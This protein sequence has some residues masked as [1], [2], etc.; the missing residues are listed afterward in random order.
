MRRRF[1]I[2]EVIQSSAM[3]CG[4]ASLKA[5]L[6]G[7]GISA[8]YGRLREACQTDVDGTSIDKLE[9]AG[10]QLGLDAAQVMLPADHLFL[11][12]AEAL[13]ALLVVRLPNGTT[14]FVVVWRRHGTWVQVMDP[15]VGRRWMRVRQLQAETYIHTQA[16]P[17][18]GWREWA[19][20]DGFLNPLRRRIRDLGIN[21]APYIDRATADA[22]WRGLATLDAAT[23]LL[24]GLGR[25][26]A[27]EKLLQKLTEKPAQIPPS[28][29]S[30]KEHGEDLHMMGAVLIH[31]S[32]TKPATAASAELLAALAEKPAAPGLQL[33]KL[34]R[35]DGFLSPLV[36]IAAIVLAASGTAVEAV[37]LRGLFELGRYLGLAGQRMWA[38]TALAVFLAALA[39]IEYPLYSGLLRAGR[40]LE[41]RLRLAFLAG[42]P[43]LGDRYFQSRLISDMAERSHSVQKLREL[44]E[45]AG[46]LLQAVAGIVITAG[47]IV[48]LYP[49]SAPYAIAAAALSLILPAVTQP[50]LSER[51]LRVRSHTGALSRF[52]LDAMIG[53]VAIR[54]HGAERSV[55]SEHEKLLGE[56][57][58][59]SLR[60]QRTAV[61]I[62]AAQLLTGYG[63]TAWL[64]L[65]R[66]SS[67]GDPAGLL[68]L[69]YWALQLPVMGQEAA[70]LA[71]RYPGLRNVTLRLLEPL[72]SIPLVGQA[73]GLPD[74]PNG[75]AAISIRDV[76][77]IAAGNTILSEVSVEIPA[78]AHVAIIG[79]SGA[80]KSSFAGLLLGW[81]RPASGEVLVDGKPLNDD[82][83]EQL[84]RGIAWV[85]PQIQLWNRSLYDN[86]RY[87]NDASQSSAMGAVIEAADLRAVLERMPDGLQTGLGESG[88]LVSG[89]EGQRVRMGRAMLRPNVRLAILDEPARGL[90]RNRRRELLRQAR[91]TWRDVTM[92][93]IT[94]DVGDTMTFERVLV[95]DQGRVVEDGAPADLAA[96]PDSKYRSL[97]EAEE[98]VRD[99]MWTAKAWRPMRM[100][101]GTLVEGER[102]ESGCPAI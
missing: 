73:L 43:R 34:L 9:E 27:S 89:G 77:V 26:Q 21:P 71:W 69:V 90:D 98:Q 76:T 46:R 84:R 74:P 47:A 40:K 23:R 63:L 2:P 11:D 66:L 6:E 13:P 79:A 93:C 10:V 24:T 86:L 55:R 58:A 33:L 19:G 83:L 14:H 28:Y 68:L 16:V 42:I 53:L 32:G 30:V 85:D 29:W 39:A 78:G 88:A 51:D 45:L 49:A 54:A 35:A 92:L 60:L 1:L 5:L 37:L 94:H 75:P 82:L 101:K 15:G 96:A 72:G 31:V 80:G 38:M 97:I 95:I 56:W 8:S 57:A 4:P 99:G 100:E 18:E 44:P 25:A 20:T 87:G 59:A 52:Y 61:A 36:L 91:S 22:G 41:C 50:V 67:G 70:H 81:H 17:T 64:V 3:D 65:A 62:E 102:K 48:W 12:E 7:F